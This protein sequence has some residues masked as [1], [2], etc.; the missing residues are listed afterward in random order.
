MVQGEKEIL[1]GL[2]LF[3]LDEAAD[4][5]VSRGKRSSEVNLQ[6]FCLRKNRE[7]GL[8]DPGRCWSSQRE[9][10]D[11]IFKKILHF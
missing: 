10:E 11:Q 7:A 5:S 3:Q 9:G 6:D 2:F 8:P 1:N 4:E